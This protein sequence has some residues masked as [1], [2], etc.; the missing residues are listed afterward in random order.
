LDGEILT[1]VHQGEV[2]Q[3]LDEQDGWYKITANGITGWCF[4]GETGG[5]AA[6]Q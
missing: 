1:L 6:K 5:Y 3:L 4:G 2:Y